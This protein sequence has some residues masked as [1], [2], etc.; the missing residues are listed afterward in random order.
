MPKWSLLSVSQF[1]DVDKHIS[2]ISSRGESGSFI[3]K[4][5][6]GERL[7]SHV[8]R[9]FKMLGENKQNLIFFLIESS[10]FDDGVLKER[11]HKLLV[12]L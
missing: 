11:I 12:L 9:L 6:V 3:N 4:L 7:L 10:E 8:L 1:S 5:H 2:N